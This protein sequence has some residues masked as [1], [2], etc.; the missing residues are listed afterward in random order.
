MIMHITVFGTGSEGLTI[1]VGLAMLGHTVTAVDIN[2]SR[3]RRFQ[4]G[5]YTGT[6]PELGENLKLVLREGLLTFTSEPEESLAKADA[7]IIAGIPGIDQEIMP[8]R[9]A[10]LRTAESLTGAI[11]SFS[12][13]IVTTRV[14]TGSCRILQD[15][16]EDALYTG[17]ATVVACPAFF[18]ETGGLKDFLNPNRIVLG[19]ESETARR[20]MDE[21]FGALLIEDPPVCHVSWE[22]AEMMRDPAGAIGTAIPAEKTE[23]KSARNAYGKIAQHR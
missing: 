19:Y 1:S 22:A 7:V 18:S 9:A 11:A 14:P 12:T 5:Y 2:K 13:V 3:T 16:L 17:A 23:K 4:R 21:I 8:D 10:V 6:D 15:W 20:N